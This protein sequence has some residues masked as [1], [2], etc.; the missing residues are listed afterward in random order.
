MYMHL[1]IYLYESVTQVVHGASSCVFHYYA[2]CPT[3]KHLWT[4]QRQVTSPLLP[5]C[6]YT[7]T[8]TATSPWAWG[9]YC[10]FPLYH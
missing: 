5:R 9:N 8:I 1:S 2:R 3:A 10:R 6:L 4:T 7:Q